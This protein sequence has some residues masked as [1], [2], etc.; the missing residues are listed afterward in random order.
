MS[1]SRRALLIRRQPQLPC[2]A[3][4]HDVLGDVFEQISVV[5]L[6]SEGAGAGLGNGGMAAEPLQ[7]VADDVV[8]RAVAPGDDLV[9]HELL[10]LGG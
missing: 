3:A 1:V 9:M 5:A 10:Q 7:G 2:A 8:L 6:G 4:F